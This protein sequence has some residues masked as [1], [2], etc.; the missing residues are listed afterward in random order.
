L[1]VVLGVLVAGPSI[2]AAPVPVDELRPDTREFERLGQWEQAC[3]AYAQL[4]AENRQQPELRDRLRQCVRHLHQTRRLRDPVYRTQVLTLPLSQALAVYEEVLEKLN[5]QYADR[6]LVPI[7]RLYQN[8]LDEFRFAFT[9]STFRQEHLAGVEPGVRATLS[10]RVRDDWA[11]RTVRDV[12]DARQ[13]VR[14]LAWE[15]NRL[16][17]VN[18]T[19]V[20]MECA[21]GACNALDEY[22]F[23]LT[24]G[25]PLDDPTVLSGDLAAYGLLLNWKDRQL[26]VARAVPGTWA[27]AQ[28]VQAGD[29]I[30]HI[31]K[32]ALDRLPQDVVAELFRGSAAVT[33]LTILPAGGAVGRVVTLPGDLPSVPEAQVERD[34]I[35]YVRLAHFHAETPQE[36]ESALLRL[37]ADGLRVLILD[38]RGNSGGSFRAAVQVADRFLPGGVIVST[39]GQQPSATKTYVAQN[40]LTAVD[41]PLVVL[42]DGD[43]ASAAEVV[44][45]ALKDNQRALLVGQTTYGKGT[46]QRLLRL[47]SGGGLWLTL[48]KFYSPR[49]QPFAC[50]GVTPHLTEPRRDAVK[51]YQLDL[52]FE[53]AARLLAMR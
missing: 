40:P 45:G 47:Q 6:D 42:V 50:V 38:L 33:E 8:G 32:H 9:D 52:A 26:V 37:R 19:V 23:L 13:A 15:V 11:G 48:A 53:Q 2:G 27:A 28:G 34:G 20:V 12:R 35:G 29:R 16:T 43:T 46:I 10:D 1:A 39:R 17:G 18:P 41:V 31:G 25:Q 44:A 22:S 30:T 7:D 51:D 21:C 3:A 24:P 5:T 4:L 49:G 36:L 14:D